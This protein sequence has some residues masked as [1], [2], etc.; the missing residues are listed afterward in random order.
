MTNLTLTILNAI[1]DEDVLPIYVPKVSFY[2]GILENSLM[3][4]ELGGSLSFS[5][6]IGSLLFSHEGSGPVI[7]IPDVA[8]K[9]SNSD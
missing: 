2:T 7:R 1:K 9:R 5:R 8:T 6:R 3:I 4:E